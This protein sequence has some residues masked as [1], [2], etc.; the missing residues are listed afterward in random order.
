MYEVQSRSIDEHEVFSRQ[1]E[2]QNLGWLYQANMDYNQEMQRVSFLDNLVSHGSLKGS[3]FRAKMLSQRRLYGLGSFGLAGFAYMHLSTLSMM[4]GPVAPVLGIVGA[5]MYGARQFAESGMIS[6]IDYIK[7]GEFKGLL[8]VSVQKSPFVSRTLIVN[9]K[10]TMAIC[11]VGAD[12]VGEEDADG[13]VIYASEYMDES[14]GVP[15][16]NGFFTVPADSHR[17]RITLEW[18]MA[19]KEDKSETDA[20]FNELI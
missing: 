9:P 1:V 17:D 16:K 15:E 20:L 18:I 6:R 7:E 8:R 4:L 3:I 13:N 11:S 19:R 5:T 2:R 12:D 10:H 14:T